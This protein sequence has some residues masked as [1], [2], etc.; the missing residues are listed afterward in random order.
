MPGDFPAN[1]ALLRQV[2]E[3]FQDTSHLI[4]SEIALARAEVKNACSIALGAGAL[5]AA[6]GIFALAGTMLLFGVVFLI[7]SFG[8]AVHWAFLI[9]AMILA[10]AAAGCF[11]AARGKIEQGLTPKRSIRQIQESIQSARELSR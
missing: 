8:L 6:T 5:F 7:A 2:A 10:A 11:F 1:A 9:V 4:A 3:I